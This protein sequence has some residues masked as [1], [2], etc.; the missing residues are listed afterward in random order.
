M[1]RRC[2]YRW[3][4]S[5]LDLLALIQKTTE[6]GDEQ[7]STSF[8]AALASLQNIRQNGRRSVDKSCKNGPFVFASIM[9]SHVVRLYLS[10]IAGLKKWGSPEAP[11]QCKDTILPLSGVSFRFTAACSVHPLFPLSSRR[12]IGMDSL[13]WRA[14]HDAKSAV[15]SKQRCHLAASFRVNI[16]AN[17]M[18][19][20]QDDRRCCSG[21]SN[22]SMVLLNTLYA[23]DRKY[24]SVL[25][26]T[27]LYADRSSFS[28]LTL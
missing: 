28:G 4:L 17:Q 3:C 19:V 25:N 20:L 24:F 22:Y 9:K 8:L 12:G 10:E 13:W 7:G 26:W 5:F 2:R 18:K 6:V 27:A 14:C 1:L 23:A 21:L 16:L 11:V 15:L